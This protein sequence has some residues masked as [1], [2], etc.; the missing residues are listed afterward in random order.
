MSAIFS[1]LLVIVSCRIGPRA[2]DVHRTTMLPP[3]VAV[4]EWYFEWVLRDWLAVIEPV[5]RFELDPCGGEQ[6][7]RYRRKELPAGQQLLAYQAR[8]GLEQL[9][10]GLRKGV[11]Q[12]NV[13]A[14]PRARIALGEVDA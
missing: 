12:R 6:V 5:V 3:A 11:G 13:A 9:R 10:F 4:G 1:P 14:E 7:Q 8:A 2:A